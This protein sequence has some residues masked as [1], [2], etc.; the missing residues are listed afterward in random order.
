MK[1][2]E[3]GPEVG[4]GLCDGDAD[5]RGGGGVAADASLGERTAATDDE[6][7]AVGADGRGGGARAVGVSG[8]ADDGGEV[9][10]GSGGGAGA[11]S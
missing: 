5:H 8:G 2:A 1:P 4:L 7:F 11:R 9:R 6:E 10:A 3:E